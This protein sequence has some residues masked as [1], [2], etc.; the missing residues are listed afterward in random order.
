MNNRKSS[1]DTRNPELIPNKEEKSNTRTPNYINLSSHI[2]DNIPKKQY[3]KKP[4]AGSR[5]SERFSKMSSNEEYSN[6]GSSN[7][8]NLKAV[9]N[10]ANNYILK[11]T[12]RSNSTENTIE[13][14]IDQINIK[15]GRKKDKLR[16]ADKKHSHIYID[17]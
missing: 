13:S 3:I 17:K 1:P 5:P 11:K 7:N 9:G 15:N 2:E 4:K 8:Q 10:N 12:A 6:I 16:L 14:S